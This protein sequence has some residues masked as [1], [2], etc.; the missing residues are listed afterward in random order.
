MSWNKQRFQE[1]LAPVM[2]T[3]DGASWDDALAVE[4]NRRYGPGT[5]TFQQITEACRSGVHEG[6]M[7]LEGDSRRRGGR[8]LEP[9]PATRNLSVDVVEIADITGPHH[10][11]PGGE[12]CAV[13][14][15]TEGARFDGNAE[16]WCV[17]PPGSGHFPSATGGR[18][19]VMFFLPGGAIEYSDADV[20]LRSGSS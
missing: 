6:W 12:A 7:G 15:V 9:T 17:Y 13:L 11:H 20:S 8:V 4:L 19:Q 16:G 10:S 14:P 2:E 1:L 18:L 3:L 5:D